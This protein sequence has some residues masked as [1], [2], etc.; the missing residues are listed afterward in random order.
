MANNSRHLLYDEIM[1]RS[2]GGILTEQ[3]LPTIYRGRAV[4]F[5]FADGVVTGREIFTC[6]DGEI[7]GPIPNGSRLETP[8]PQW[9]RL[10]ARPHSSHAFVVSLRPVTVG[11]LAVPVSPFPVTFDD[12]QVGMLQVDCRLR[13]LIRCR[14]PRRLVE[15]YRQGAFS[16][17]EEEGIWALRAAAQELLPSLGEYVRVASPMD[18][19]GQVDG[20]LAAD[21]ARR[22]ARRAEELAP[23]MGVSSPDLTLAVTN[24]DTILQQA[25]RSYELSAA[26]R[27]KLIDATLTVYTRDT[28][29]PQIARV[30]AGYVQANPGV[31]EGELVQLCGKLKALSQ[32]NS[33]Q[34]IFTTAV[35]LGLIPPQRP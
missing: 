15:D 25:N 26:V 20:A 14:S 19:V 30:L 28:F 23:W 32:H 3:P 10:L 18:A 22:I 1:L 16:T 17:P 31:S 8:I 29:S 35:S 5:L 7:C 33:P 21:L 34:Q 27:Q 12:G 6:F 4:L 2:D 13:A 11:E 24:V 9:E